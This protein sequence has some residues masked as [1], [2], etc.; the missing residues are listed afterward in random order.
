MVSRV[1]SPLVRLSERLPGPGS[2][3][4]CSRVVAEHAGE[5]P[6]AEIAVPAVNLVEETTKLSSGPVSAPAVPMLYGWR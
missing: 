4:G 5:A 2:L 6:A 1:V 3:G